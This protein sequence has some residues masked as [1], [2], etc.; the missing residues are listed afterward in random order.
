MSYTME[1]STCGCDQGPYKV[2]KKALWGSLWGCFML[3]I[4]IRIFF[5][6]MV[7]WIMFRHSSVEAAGTVIRSCVLRILYVCKYFSFF[8]F[9]M[10]S[11]E[12]MCSYGNY[13]FFF[14]FSVCHI[15]L[16]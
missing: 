1:A 11:I 2:K 4:N 10:G 12:K 5:R 13:L 9:S 7:S 16:I 15:L 8:L 6:D 3:F 14:L